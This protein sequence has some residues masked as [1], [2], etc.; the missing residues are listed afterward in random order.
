MNDMLR[1]QIDGATEEQIRDLHD[2]HYEGASAE[3][4]LAIGNRTIINQRVYIAATSVSVGPS[5]RS[6]IFTA[7][8]TRNS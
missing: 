7:Y 3:C 5:K 6:V 4:W 8:P 2:L 1:I